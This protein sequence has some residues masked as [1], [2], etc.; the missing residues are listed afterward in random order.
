MVNSPLLGREIVEVGKPL[1]VGAQMQSRQGMLEARPAC[2]LSVKEAKGSSNCGDDAS[3]P[4]HKA[5]HPLLWLNSKLG[6]D[7]SG[8]CVI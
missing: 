4:R 7:G 1:E 2:G 5:Q 8:I 6:A 3:M